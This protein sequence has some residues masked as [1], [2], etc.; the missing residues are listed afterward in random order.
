MKLEARRERRGPAA[1]TIRSLSLC[2]VVVVCVAVEPA[3]ERKE[4]EEN[5][6]WLGGR[7]DG[8]TDVCVLP[9]Y[10]HLAHKGETEKAFNK[11]LLIV[12]QL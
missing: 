8:R 10:A 11:M 12:V 3:K 2:V 9:M 7:T 5:R 6:T 4:E 1:V